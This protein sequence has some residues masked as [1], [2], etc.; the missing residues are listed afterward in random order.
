MVR[1]D[2]PLEPLD[3]GGV[4][5][6]WPERL[7]GDG[8][9][10]DAL[11]HNRLVSSTARVGVK[12]KPYP[13]PVLPSIMSIERGARAVGDRIAERDDPPCRGR[14]QHIKRLQPEH[15]CRR[16]GK[17]LCRLEAGDIPGAVGAQVGSRSRVRVLARPHVSA[18]EVETDRQVLPRQHADL[19][20]IALHA[21]TWRD[22][23]SGRPVEEHRSVGTREERCPTHP[24]AHVDRVDDQRPRPE[25]VVESEAHRS[26]RDGN[27][28]DHPDR[29]VGDRRGAQSLL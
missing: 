13:Q 9:A 26:T 24:L 17:R 28:R 21:P 29:G 7:T 18:R 11:V 1:Q 2:V 15:R 4:V 16:L 22:S 25:R 3:P 23:N 14:G 10:A 8:V 19:H 5:W 6:G 12:G 20:R 27:P